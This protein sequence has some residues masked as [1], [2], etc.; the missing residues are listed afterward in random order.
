MISERDVMFN[1]GETRMEEE[2]VKKRVYGSEAD[3]CVEI[4]RVLSVTQLHG[5][6]EALHPELLRLRASSC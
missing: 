1:W 6:A 2:E 4:L 3:G 5:D